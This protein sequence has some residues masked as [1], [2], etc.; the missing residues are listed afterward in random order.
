MYSYNIGLMCKW[1]LL[2]FSWMG[3]P[4]VVLLIS[5]LFFQIPNY[6]QKNKIC[7]HATFSKQ[8]TCPWIQNSTTIACESEELFGTLFSVHFDHRMGFHHEIFAT[9]CSACLLL[10]LDFEITKKKKKCERNEKN[11]K[12][13]KAGGPVQTI[14]RG[15][16]LQS[17]YAM[18]LLVFPFK[19]R[20]S[21]RIINTW[22]CVVIKARCSWMLTENINLPSQVG[23]Q[24]CFG[25]TCKTKYVS[26]F[27]FPFSR[28]YK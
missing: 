17:N 6:A 24:L 23:S 8:P 18:T 12:K 9:K 26:S 16:K 5:F 2:E 22:T 20:T 15:S 1:I 25:N 21:K 19:R 11:E 14:W 4:L 7:E 10:S 27:F 28:P 3:T 13:R